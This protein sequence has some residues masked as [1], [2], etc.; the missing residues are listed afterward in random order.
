MSDKVKVVL[1]GQA[2]CSFVRV[3]MVYK[4]EV[5]ELVN[6][7]EMIINNLDHP[8]ATYTIEWWDNLTATPQQDNRTMQDDT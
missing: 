2:I 3:M 1:V 6:E 5:D 7:E 4:D 8:D